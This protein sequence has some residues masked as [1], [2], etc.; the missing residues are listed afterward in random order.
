METHHAN[1]QPLYPARYD[2]P[3]TAFRMLLP[4][5]SNAMSSSLSTRLHSVLR[6]LLLLQTRARSTSNDW[7]TGSASSNHLNTTTINGSLSPGQ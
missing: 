7:R 1:T 6:I 3:I 5:G 2:E 4:M